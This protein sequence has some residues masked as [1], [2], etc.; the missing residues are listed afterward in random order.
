LTDVSS[1]HPWF[2]LEL[3]PTCNLDCIY[4]CNPWTSDVD[5][6][7]P[8]DRG[9]LAELLRRLVSEA[10]PSGITISGGEPLLDPDLPSLAGLASSLVPSVTVATNGTLLTPGL[11]RE[12]AGAG[13]TAFQISVP[14]SC[15]ETFDEL[16]GAPLLE[17]ALEGVSAAAASGASVCAA[18]TLTRINYGECADAMRLA[19]AFGASSFQIN[20]LAF[21]GRA[22]AAWNSLSPDAGQVAEAVIDARRRSTEY[23]IPVFAGIPLEP[24]VLPTGLLDGIGNC[25]CICARLKWAVDPA[26]RLRPCEQSP[27]VIGDLATC[28]FQELAGSGPAEE[29]RAWAPSGSCGGCT[30]E[31]D[32]HGG[33]RYSAS[34]VIPD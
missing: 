26:G 4:C 24:C 5:P 9:S 18:Y 7:C 15:E 6:P 14:A 31:P 20:R 12:L 33:C 1:S 25:G 13:V 28:G 23:G 22:S 8:V 27:V 30:F 11:A 29:F 10:R 34:P 3:V 32:C 16:C 21:G 2:V 19:F 17:D